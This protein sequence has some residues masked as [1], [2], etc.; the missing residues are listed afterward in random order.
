MPLIL[1]NSKSSAKNLPKL[2]E[3]Y[4]LFGLFFFSGVAGRNQ[5][6]KNNLKLDP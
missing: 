6:W 1:G 5:W 2:L 3:D 4:Q